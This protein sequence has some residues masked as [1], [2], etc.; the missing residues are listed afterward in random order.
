MK[1]VNLLPPSH[2]IHR[3]GGR[4]GSAYVVLGMLGVLLVAVLSYVLTANQ[5]T[6]KQDELTRAQQET[7]AAQA[8]AAALGSFGDFSSIKVTREQSVAQ[9]AQARLDWERLMRELS[10]VIPEDVFVNSLDATGV[11]AAAQPGAEAAGGP[12]LKLGGCAPSHPDVAT[13]MVRLR[14]LSGTKDV[15]LSDSTTVDSGGGSTTGGGGSTGGC[16]GVAFTVNVDFDPA[17]TAA[18]GV[19]EHLGGGA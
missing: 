3:G 14:R 6:S 18:E 4:P 2:R 13:L 8:Q 19:P 11:P 7:Q 15:R 12:G 17:P 10:R 9:L 16:D 5:V 1:P